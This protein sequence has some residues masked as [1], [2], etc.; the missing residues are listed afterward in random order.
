[1]DKKRQ[2]RLG[3]LA[4][5]GVV[6]LGL[7]IRIGA[8]A[9]D[10]DGPPAPTPRTVVQAQAVTPQQATFATS[11]TVVAAPSQSTPTAVPT[12]VPTAAP[13][14]MPTQPPPPT[15][16]PSLN[17]P[18][19]TVLELGQVWKQDGLELTVLPPLELHP[20]GI[21]ILY[22]LTNRR[23]N[24]VIL[25]YDQGNVFSLVENTGR[26]LTMTNTR[27]GVTLSLTIGAGD[28]I[29]TWIAWKG[30]LTRPE[31]TE[32]IITANGVASITNARWRIP[33]YH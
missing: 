30:D 27:D 8:S 28:K 1:M 18:E 12:P 21:L 29:E 32:L 25:R 17:A 7:L 5:L 24:P 16:T 2:Y 6:T 11:V 15:P 20:D 14:P 13:T 23:G 26:R 31:I 10:S 9:L 33:I 19:G 4:I 22:R 3:A